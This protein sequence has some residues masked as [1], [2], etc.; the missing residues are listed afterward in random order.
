ME[1]LDFEI[2]IGLASGLDYPIMVRSAAGDATETMHF[3]FD[4]LA[5]ES[6][7]DKLQ[8]ALLRSAGTYRRVITPEEQAV[9]DFGRDLFN[10]LLT[11]EI[12]SLFDLR[13]REAQAFGKG[14]RIKLRIRAPELAALPWEFMYDSRRGEFLCLSRYTPL[15]RY[16]ELFQPTQPLAVT[17]PLRILGMIASPS[18]LPTLNV[19]RE[20]QRV[21]EATKD[22]R[23]KKL[24]ELIWLD[25]QTWR[26]L[27]KAMRG[28]PW[29]IF[30]F[31]GHG[32]FDVNREEGFMALA[33]DHGDTQRFHATQLARL[34]ADHS[35]LRFCLLNACEGARSSGRDIFS[36][37]ASIV[38][39]RGIP[40]V[41]AM[42]Y[43]ITDRAAVEFARAFY[44]SIADNMP[45][46]AAV[47]E[48]RKAVSL[49]V[50]GS[51]EWGT[52]VLYMRSSD[53]VLFN[54]TKGRTGRITQPSAGPVA[55]RLVVRQGKQRGRVYPITTVAST[56]GRESSVSIFV[57]DNLI[58]RRHARVFQ[59]DNKLFIEDLGSRNGTFLNRK[60]ITEP[61]ELKASDVIRV[62][63][64]V[65]E[66]ELQ[67]ATA[68][69]Q[70][71]S[72]GQDTEEVKLDEVIAEANE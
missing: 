3:P 38:V 26:D 52:P 44:E 6:R 61:T 48:A 2:E 28:G 5:L 30:H 35:S 53:G 68:P 59:Q 13:Y 66:V 69:I 21:E 65:L 31:I 33:D 11:G 47:V 29:H 57:D 64:T 71:A 14:L 45:V 36:S 17:A 63:D 39:R 70:L 24:L 19:E 49:A 20:R 51:V 18:D 16:P 34:L 40:A 7:L 10:A 22:L 60:A 8:I 72:S 32:G 23:N 9:Q 41:L 27:Q 54:L 56:I 37:T 55:A 43:E 25:G 50:S 46:D 1:F 15:V 67:P 58:S 4:E 12:R 62:G 42:Q